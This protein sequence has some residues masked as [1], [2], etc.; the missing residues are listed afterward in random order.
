VPTNY[1]LCGVCYSGKTTLVGKLR[2][3]FKFPHV[4]LDALK[5][6]RGYRG[7]GDGAVPKPVWREIFREA[8]ALLQREF[9]GGRSLINESA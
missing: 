1:L 7:V 5:A 3:R 8:D 9:A 6:G 2:E 4:N